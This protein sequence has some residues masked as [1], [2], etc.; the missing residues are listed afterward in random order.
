MFKNLKF[1]K[2]FIILFFS[3]SAICFFFIDYTEESDIW[4]LL[5]HGRYVLNNGFPHIDILSMHTGLNFVMQQWLSSVIF[6][7]IYNYLGKIAF[8]VF[9]FVLNLIMTFLMYKLCL[10][11]SNNKKFASCFMSVITM[12]LLQRSFIVPRPQMFTYII[13]LVLLI[14]LELFSSKRKKYIYCLPIL[15]ILLINFHGAM[16]PILFIFCMP[17][18]AELILKKDKD[19]FKLLSIML[20][21]VLVGLINPYGIETL[22]YSL[23]SY[24]LEYIRLVVGEM[25]SFNLLGEPFVIYWS[26]FIVLVFFICNLLILKYSNKKNIRVAHLLLFYG[27]F[28]MSL[29]SVRNIS[30]FIIGTLPFLVKYFQFKDINKFELNKGWIINYIIIFIIFIAVFIFALNDN[31]HIFE[32]VVN[33][34][35]VYLNNHEENKNVKI[36]TEYHFGSTFEYYGY[37]PYLDTRAEV[38]IKKMNKKEDILEEYIRFN[39]D[40][41][42]RDEFIKKYDFDYYVLLDEYFE[43]VEYLINYEDIDYELVLAHEKF[44]LVKKVSE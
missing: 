33:D 11:V 38:F 5:S 44:F 36:Y 12:V 2:N 20:L 17:Y 24:G 32:H 3:F 18:V 25:R 29:S 16:W 1:S 42:F 21:S 26:G 23:K 28:F 39:T 40:I 35:V 14:M 30:L 31:R 41:S 13:L 8:Y 4:F 15:S 19:V 43:L 6:Y 34:A 22:L 37:K 27:T 7:I 9:I 10:I